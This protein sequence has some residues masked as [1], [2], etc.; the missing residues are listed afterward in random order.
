MAKKVKFVFILSS[1]IFI[2]CITTQAYFNDQSI[3]SSLNF[4]AADHWSRTATATPE[5]IQS[6][7][8]SPT[9]DVSP[10]PAACF[11][12]ASGIVLI[13]EVMANPVGEDNAAKPNGEWIELYNT[14]SCEIDLK[15]WALYEG[16]GKKLP[17]IAGNTGSGSTIIAPKGLMVVYRNE[18]SFTLNNDTDEVRLYWSESPLSAN[19]ADNFSYSNTKEG[20]SWSRV[21]N[22]GDWVAEKDPTA[23]AANI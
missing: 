8:P 3:V 15:D 4:N 17:I 14:T 12:Y 10:S 7:T 23:G 11:D 6:P 22:G 13:N 5:P 2:S 19:L 20:K 9:P 21:P 18:Y 16:S 1:L